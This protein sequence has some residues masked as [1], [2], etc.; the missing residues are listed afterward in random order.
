MYH[1]TSAGIFFRRE[2]TECF[3]GIVSRYFFYPFSYNSSIPDDYLYDE[4]FT[5]PHS[6]NFCT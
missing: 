5:T 3:P 2:S 1:V 6:L 4:A